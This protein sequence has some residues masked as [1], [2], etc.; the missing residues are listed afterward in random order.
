MPNSDYLYYNV[1]ASSPLVPLFYLS[2]VYTTTFWHPSANHPVLNQERLIQWM[3]GPILDTT[4]ALMPCYGPITYL[5][6]IHRVTRMIKFCQHVVVQRP[7]STIRVT[8]PVAVATFVAKTRRFN[9]FCLMSTLY[10]PDRLS[11]FWEA[12]TGGGRE[13]HYSL[14]EI[15]RV[16]LM[17]YC[18]KHY[19]CMFGFLS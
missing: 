15:A 8:P 6:E 9:I 5:Q 12:Q 19:I 11:E 10:T 7:V 2:T 17:K 13:H 16:H 4:L 1:S 18:S 3:K 14:P